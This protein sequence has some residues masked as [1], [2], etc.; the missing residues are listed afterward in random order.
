MS[1]GFW[2][3]FSFLFLNFIVAPLGHNAA[4]NEAFIG[5]LRKNLTV[6]EWQ[7]DR[8]ECQ[9]GEEIYSGGANQ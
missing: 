2:L 4:T 6:M 8:V 7:F 1:V 9:F 5:L 3:C